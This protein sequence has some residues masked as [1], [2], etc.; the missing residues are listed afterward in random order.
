[1][2]AFAIMHDREPW[3]ERWEERRAETEEGEVMSPW[4]GWAE[5]PLDWRDWQRAVRASSEDEEEGRSL[6]VKA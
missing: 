3:T 2:P 4:K 6:R 1:M 5:C